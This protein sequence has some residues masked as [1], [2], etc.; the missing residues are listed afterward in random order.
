MGREEGECHC[1]GPRRHIPSTGSYSAPKCPFPR[2][3]AAKRL[4]CGIRGSG[5][6][7]DLLK[8]ARTDL[9]GVESRGTLGWMCGCSLQ[10]LGERHV[11][12][13]VSP[14]ALK[15]VGFNWSSTLPTAPSDA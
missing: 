5:G 2:P 6:R 3:A 4:G 15:V 8:P 13:L 11:D 9:K 12:P 14:V 10:F 7:L 1:Q